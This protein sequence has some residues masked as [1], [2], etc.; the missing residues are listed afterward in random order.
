MAMVC[1]RAFSPVMSG[2]VTR[3]ERDGRRIQADA[4][5]ISSQFANKEFFALPRYLSEVFSTIMDVKVE[6]VKERKKLE[7]LLLVAC[8]RGLLEDARQLVH[9]SGVHRFELVRDRKGRT[10]M[11]LAAA[12]GRKAVLEFLWSKAADMDTEDDEGRT[13]LHLAAANGHVDCVRLLVDK[14]EAFMDG[15][16]GIHGFTAVEMAACRGHED[17]VEAL[18]GRGCSRGASAEALLRVKREGEERGFGLGNDDKDNIP[19]V[20]GGPEEHE[21]RISWT[22]AAAIVAVLLGMILAWWGSFRHSFSS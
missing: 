6:E 3:M 21:R 22:I 5:Q 15:T 10:P 20:G 12:R 18:V 8:E 17:V 14:G 19:S 1:L 13:P 2:R 4:S 7:S 11:H 16:E 9:L